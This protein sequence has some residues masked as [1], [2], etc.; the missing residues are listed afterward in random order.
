MGSDGRLIVHGATPSGQ[1]WTDFQQKQTVEVYQ[2]MVTR[3]AA[4]CC[5][6]LPAAVGRLDRG[7]ILTRMADPC[8]D[9]RWRPQV[10]VADPEQW[11]LPNRKDACVGF[12]HGLLLVCVRPL[13][14]TPQTTTQQPAMGAQ[15]HEGL[16]VVCRRGWV[17]QCGHG[18]VA[19]R[20]CLTPPVPRHRLSTEEWRAQV[21]GVVAW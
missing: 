10:A 11:E 3:F 6:P 2:I 5:T 16:A 17:T 7:L 13:T 20:L 18:C 12:V 19:L 15:P 14:T 4:C 21:G 9:V 8:F 1:K